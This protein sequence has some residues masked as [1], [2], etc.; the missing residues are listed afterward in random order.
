MKKIIVLSCMMAGS[1]FIPVQSMAE[2][3]N[4]LSTNMSNTFVQIIDNKGGVSGT[5]QAT[6]SNNGKISGLITNDLPNSAYNDG[7]PL[8][9]LNCNIDLDKVYNNTSEPIKILAGC[10]NNTIYSRMENDI[11]F[12][13]NIYGARNGFYSYSRPVKIKNQSVSNG[14]EVRYLQANILIRANQGGSLEAKRLGI[15]VTPAKYANNIYITYENSKSVDIVGKSTKMSDGGIA[16]VYLLNGNDPATSEKTLIET[17]SNMSS[18]FDANVD[19]NGVYD[20]S[21]AKNLLKYASKYMNNYASNLLILDYGN[22]IEPKYKEGDGEQAVEGLTISI[23]D[24]SYYRNECTGEGVL[25][26]QKATLSFDV[27][28]DVDRYLV[29]NVSYIEEGVIEGAITKISGIKEGTDLKSNK[30]SNDYSKVYNYNYNSEFSKFSSNLAD[31]IG[32]KSSA[33]NNLFNIG[34]IDKYNDIEW[35]A[36]AN[37]GVASLRDDSIIKQYWYEQKIKEEGY[38][39]TRTR[40]FTGVTG[41]SNGRPISGTKTTTYVDYVPPIYEYELKYSC[42]YNTEKNS[43]C[44]THFCEKPKEERNIYSWNVGNFSDC[45]NINTNGVGQMSRNVVCKDQNNVIV[46]DSKCNGNKPSTNEACA[47]D[48]I[49]QQVNNY[50]GNINAKLRVTLAWYNPDDLD[51][52]ANW[53]GGGEI[54]FNNKQGILDI[55]MNDSAGGKQDRNNPVENLSFKNN[56]PNGRYSIYV[57]N[58][59]R[60]SSSNVGFT[61]DIKDKYQRYQFYKPDGVVKGKKSKWSCIWFDVNNEKITNIGSCKEDVNRI[62]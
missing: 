37:G 39:I 53:P 62:M 15:N 35:S 42:I 38:Y 56:M 5:V 48:K 61:I 30:V 28:R 24:R 31:P 58:F 54:S 41:Y 60:R 1:L 14:Y 17:I 52:H 6:G 43:F 19:S 4:Q 29:D 47:I 21:G 11:K 12:S 34:S 32:E 51:I 49:E 25:Y 16:K 55:D 44:S 27:N 59:N 9:R 46:S 36:Y 10:I 45:K 22:P 26:N 2:T 33:P 40:T 23:P 18:S 8:R 7:S 57:V 50:G 20:N 3:Y 13:M